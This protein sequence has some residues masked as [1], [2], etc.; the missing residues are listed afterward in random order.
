MANFFD[1]NNL[2]EEQKNR[3]DSAVVEYKKIFEKNTIEQFNLLSKEEQSEILNFS[4][5]EKRIGINYSI[6]ESSA[7]FYRL[8][9]NKKGLV[10]PPPCSYSYPW[11]SVIEEDGPWELDLEL[12]I[13][14]SFWDNLLGNRCIMIDQTP[15]KIV[16]KVSDIE[17]HITYGKWE[18]LNYLWKLKLEDK[19]C[20]ETTTFIACHHKEKE[21]I[22][23]LDDLKEEIKFH[24]KNHF[25]KLKL[26]TDNDY[27]ESYKKELE[28]QYKS[29]GLAIL[30]TQL[31]SA[32][33]LKEERE[34]A[35]LPL[36][37]SN[38]EL[39]KEVNQKVKDYL[40]RGFFIKNGNEMFVKVWNLYKIQ[41]EV[42]DSIYLN[43]E[44][45]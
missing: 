29:I 14:N 22:T 11:Y 16:K 15:W 39:E 38:D 20:E 2:S 19:S 45:L 37:Y 5:D 10:Y 23:T 31:R 36:D 13:N 32:Q 21:R 12:E 42:N 40:D 34:K 4:S 44:D 6:D 35:N 33:F 41:G 8:L 27:Y 25:N 26:L 43:F 7:L 28:V 18:S 24:F 9:N 30:D 17:Y 1:K 3:W